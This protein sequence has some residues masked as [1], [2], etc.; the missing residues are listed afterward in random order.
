MAALTALRIRSTN[1]WAEQVVPGTDVPLLP[2]MILLL[3]QPRVQDTLRHRGL[4]NVAD[5]ARR[6]LVVM[7]ASEGEDGA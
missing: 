2:Q 4:D 5:Y 6:L 7:Q 1:E 3:N